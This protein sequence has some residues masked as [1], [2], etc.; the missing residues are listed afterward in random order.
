MKA[1]ILSVL[2]AVV[3]AAAAGFVLDSTFS[4]SADETFATPYT[5]VGESGAIGTRHFDGKL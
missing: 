4:R 5:R 1:F 3:L 2:T